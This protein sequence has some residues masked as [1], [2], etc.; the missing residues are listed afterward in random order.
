MAKTHYLPDSDSERIIWFKN[1]TDQLA[2]QAAQLGFA[3]AEITAI[4]NDQLAFAYM[5]GLRETIKQFTQRV[6]NYKDT[7]RNGP[8]GILLGPY[9]TSPA[10]GVAPVVVASGVFKRLSRTVDRI[11]AHPN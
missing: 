3:A 2:S 11:K 6:T 8:I 5:V 9:P 10:I 4:V 7:L 1:F